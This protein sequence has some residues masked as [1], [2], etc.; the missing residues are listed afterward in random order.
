MSTE[1]VIMNQPHGAAPEHSSTD[2]V[3]S[4][5][6]TTIAY[7]RFGHGPGIVLL[8]GAMESA[9]SH[10]QLAEALADAF[11]VYVPDRRGRG[12]SLPQSQDY[13]MA[14]EVEDLA[15]LLDKTAAYNVFGVSSGAVITL[16]A[17]LTLPVIHKVALYEPPLS[18]KRSEASAILARYDREMA[19]GKLAAALVTG[20]KGAK[21]GPPIFSVMPRWLLESLTTM[22]INGEAKRGSGEYMPMR[23]LAPTLHNDFQLIA[24][25]SERLQAFK[26]VH[27]EA[28]LLGGSRSPAYLKSALDSLEQILPHARRIEFPGLDHAAS[29][30]SDRGGQPQLVADELRRFFA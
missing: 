24:D 14:K 18:L 21:M 12:L 27:A 5:D 2:S 20:M 10:V 25:M 4:A 8:H 1:T 23:A 26:A 3:K 15:A 22:A 29:G 9:Q 7:R 30:N 19:D 28:L 6:G 11:T 13:S 17:A 16:Q